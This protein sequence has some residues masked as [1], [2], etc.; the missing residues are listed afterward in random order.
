MYDVDRPVHQLQQRLLEPSEASTSSLA[1]LLNDQIDHAQGELLLCISSHN[2][3]ERSLVS[4]FDLPDRSSSPTRAEPGPSLPLVTSEDIQ[5][6][7]KSIREAANEVSLFTSI[8]WNPLEENNT[9]EEDALGR[10]APETSTNDDDTQRAWTAQD[11]LFVLIRA[12][13]HTAEELLELRVAVVGNVDAGKST[14]LG[15]MTKGRLDDGRGRARVSLFRH[16]HEIESGRTSS[17]GM[18]IL[19]FG[20]LGNEVMADLAAP[21]SGSNTVTTAAIRKKDLSWDEI[22]K[23]AA[24]VVGFIDLAGHERYFKVSFIMKIR[25]VC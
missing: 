5:K 14:L 4:L 15:V 18:E 22:C 10:Y 11:T 13:P 1:S 3:N 9:L 25:K 20:P 16:K 23:E 19:G 24:K 17:V 21:A 8:L 7:F 6:A 2:L 12:K